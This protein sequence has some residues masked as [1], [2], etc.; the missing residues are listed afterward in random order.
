MQPEPRPRTILYIDNTSTFGGAIN[1]LAEL[2]TGLDPARF[3]PV[4]VTA[5]PQ[6]LLDERF[7]GVR[8]R[9]L[10]PRLPWV[11]DPIRRR[12][13]SIPGL[14]SGVG[15]AAVQAAHSAYWFQRYTRPEARTYANVAR[16]EGAE[17]VHLNNNLESQQSG[18]L[19]AG[20][21][22]LPCVVH[23]RSFQIPRPSL[24]RLAPRATRHI[25][26]SRAVRDNLRDVGASPDTIEVIHDG[27]DPTRFTVGEA[28]SAAEREKLGLGSDTPAVGIFGRIVP[29]KGI[30]EFILAFRK[31]LSRRPDARGF[32]VGGRSDGDE[33]YFERVTHLARAADLEGRLALTGYRPDVRA[34]MAAMDVVAHASTEPEPFG[35]VL[36]EAMSLGKPVVATRGGGPDDIVVPGQTGTLVARGD[37]SAMAQ[38]IFRLLENPR[39]AEAMGARGRDRV[40]SAFST[41]LYATK[42]MRLYDQLLHS[43]EPPAHS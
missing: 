16:E 17:V 6:D 20:L 12:L 18:V 4:V 32:V 26:I 28:E 29:W 2:V 8:T 15:R 14:R 33:S 22:G 36:I 27:I 31:V 41:T 9:R 7:P 43:E 38:A 1:S 39:E 5:Q 13:L 35:M 10:E 42:T 19:A 37:V 30:V 23:S 21:C 34:T 11:H 24:R 40:E 3:R 25:A